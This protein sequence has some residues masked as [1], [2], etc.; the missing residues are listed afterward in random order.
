M[1]YPP[2]FILSA[3]RHCSYCR[4]SPEPNPASFLFANLHVP[5]G[6][7]GHKHPP[8]LDVGEFERGAVHGVHQLFVDGLRREIGLN[9]HL[10]GHVLYTDADFHAD[11]QGLWGSY[12]VYRRH[13]PSGR[14]RLFAGRGIALK[15]LGAAAIVIVVAFAVGI[16]AGWGTSL[17]AAWLEPTAPSP[18]AT[19]TPTPSPSQTPT[20]DVSL[21]PMEPITRTIDAADRLAGLRTLQYPIHA[22]GTFTPVPA[23]TATTPDADIV[24]YVR[25]DVED[26]LQMTNGT[27]SSF[28]MS[29]LNDPQ[30]WGQEGPTAYV[31]TEGAP[32]IRI[33]FASPFTAAALCPTPHEPAVLAPSAT[34]SSSPSPSPTAAPTAVQC[35]AQGAIVVSVYDWIQGV[36]GFGEERTDARIYLLNH[37]LGHVLGKPD[38]ACKKGVAELM[39]DQRTLPKKCTPNPWPFPAKD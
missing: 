35:A 37:G 39:V 26:G 30:G 8:A 2:L 27:L 36:P 5:D 32:D 25:I 4:L 34:V 3:I 17:F 23:P 14:R 1:Y 18:S 33:V 12:Y 15:S 11:L 20:A 16:A 10:S 9:D 6:G 22:D 21:P 24:Q 28:V 31:Q 19:P 7:A 38:V 29:A 13:M